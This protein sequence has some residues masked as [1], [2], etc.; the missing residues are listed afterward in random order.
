MAIRDNEDK[1]VQAAIWNSSEKHVAAML[2]PILN[3]A[4]RTPEVSRLLAH[5]AQLAA[6]QNL[7]QA[8][9]R[10]VAVLAK[11]V[12]GTFTTWQFEMLKGFVDGM[13]SKTAARHSDD[14][15]SQALKQLTPIFMQA[16][17]ISQNP[18]AAEAD[19]LSA[20]RMLGRGALDPDQDVGLLGALVKPAQSAALQK[21]ALDTL[22]RLNRP[23]VASTLLA[24]W[25]QL[26]PSVRADVLN[27]LLSRDEWADQLLRALER[28]QIAVGEVSPA[29]QQILL[30][31]RGDS[32]R[33][34]A[35]KIFAAQNTDRQ[36]VVRNYESVKELTTNPGR[37]ALLYRQNC[38][39][40]HRLKG[41]GN[42]VGP[43]LGTVA[44][45]PIGTFLV[46]VLD[47]NQALETK[48]VSYTATTRGGREVTGIIASENPSSMTIRSPGGAEEV[49]ARTDIQS[50]ASSK[51]SL[52]P[53]GLENVLTPQDM[54]DLIAFIRSR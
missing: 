53:D 52:M 25:H 27:T 24:S 34:R 12:D 37:G 20:I 6:A 36:Q 35:G 9:A 48:Y 23:L 29:H 31:Q 39:T 21:A 22:K 8:V 18:E 46:A 44:D 32:V 30:K 5:L 4:K 11:P 3:S 47:P 54:A 1:N 45:K 15:L 7:Q 28:G 26:S 41:E 33:E 38:A 43:D 51:L 50:L 42:E 2:D 17:Q 10:I 13:D 49:I 19:R 40:C 14:A 16:R